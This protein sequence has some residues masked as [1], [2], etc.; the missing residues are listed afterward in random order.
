MVKPEELIDSMME[1]LIL[2]CEIRNSLS[3]E[4]NARI[5]KR[6]KELEAQIEKLKQR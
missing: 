4:D 1:E 3:E 5:E 2:L 6:I